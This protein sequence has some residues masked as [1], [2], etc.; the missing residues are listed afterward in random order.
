MF[1]ILE[2]RV[3]TAFETFM[4]DVSVFNKKGCVCVCSPSP[5]LSND[6]LAS[7]HYPVVIVG[8]TSQPQRV[9]P[10]IH[11]CFLHHMEVPPPSEREREG[12]LTGLSSESHVAPDMDWP[13]IAKRT[14]VRIIV[15]P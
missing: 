7:R 8:T 1:S 15:Q 9:S 3:A 5:A 13:D 12:L 2:P 4:S 14:A 10:Q 6:P 11:A